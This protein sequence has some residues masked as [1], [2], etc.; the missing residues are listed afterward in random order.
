M[1]LLGR[2]TLYD[3]LRPQKKEAGVMG[4]MRLLTGIAGAEA[5]GRPTIWTVCKDLIAVQLRPQIFFLSEHTTPHFTL[6]ISSLTRACSRYI[7][8]GINCLGHWHQH[9]HIVA[10]RST[11]ILV[12][13][14]RGSCLMDS[15][16]DRCRSW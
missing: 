11:S 1:L 8:Y 6:Q 7:R 15:T 2:E 3:R 10:G 5:T 9:N 13:S 14:F 4:R 12:Q 16:D